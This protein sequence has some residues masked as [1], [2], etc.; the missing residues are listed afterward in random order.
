ML[1]RVYCFLSF[2]LVALA[3]PDISGV[4]CVL[5]AAV[6]YGLFWYSLFLYQYSSWKSNFLHS[7][8]WF[9]LIEAFHFSW[10]LSDAYVGSCIYVFWFLLIAFLATSF[11]LFS[12]LLMVCLQKKWLQMLWFLPGIWVA[13]EMSRFYFLLSGISLDYLGWPL[14]A[15]AYG[16]QFGSFFGWS[17]HSFVVVACGIS[18]VSFLIYRCKKFGWLWVGC[19]LFPYMLGGSFYEYLKRNLSPNQELHVVILQPAIPL[20]A[21][22]KNDTS[23]LAIWQHFINLLSEV[24]KPVDLV[25]FPEVTVPFYGHNKVYAPD[26]S[27]RILSAMVDDIVECESPLSNFDWM[28]IL[29]KHFDCPIFLGLERW[30]YKNGECYL[31][32]AAECI[33]QIGEIFGYDKRILVPGGEYIPCGHIGFLVCK[34]FFPKYALHYRRVPGSRSGVISLPHLPVIGVSICYEETFGQLLRQYKKRGAELLVNMTND[35]W[36]P[37]SRLPLVHFYHGILRNQELGLPCIRSCQT[38]VTVAADSLGRI[39]GILPFESSSSRAQAA[40]LQV[41]LPI[42][43]YFTLYSQCGDFPMYIVSLFSLLFAGMF[44][45]KKLLCKIS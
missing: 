13:I 16:R 44:I 45:L 24:K 7:F 5:G 20:A 27:C 29:S 34:R 42:T 33:T 19:V 23:S 10:M 6:G 14:G 40:I 11:A 43:S 8:V 17:G 38:G 35:G 39:V 36:Y 41:T 37:R 21:E 25:V 4:G 31:Y 32:N 15:T 28:F 1:K 18:L 22:Q 3:Q 12:V 30:E 26:K 2:F 9:L